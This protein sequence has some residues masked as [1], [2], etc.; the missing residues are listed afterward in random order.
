MKNESSRSRRIPACLA[1][2]AFLYSACGAASAAPT[3]DVRTMTPRYGEIAQS[4]QVYGTIGTAP[5]NSVS[6][7]LPYA[8]RLVQLRVENGQRIARGGA[9]FVVQADP[10]V[11]ATARQAATAAELARGELARTQA[12]FAQSLATRSQLETAR[13][14]ALDAQSALDAQQA[15]GLGNGRVTV[16]APADG[17]VAQIAVLP[18]ER[19]QAGTAILRLALRSA[20][21]PNVTLG[22]D[23]ADAAQLRA[24]DPISVSGLSPALG[25]VRAQGRIVVIGAAVDPQTR[26]VDVD[27]TVALNNDGL[28][29]G[30]H[31]KGEISTRA[32]QHWIIP[33]SALLSDG[34]GEYVYQIGKDL[35]AHR[36]DVVKRIENSD[37]YGVDGDL[38]AQRPLVV[39]GNYELRDGDAVRVE[40]NSPA[41]VQKG[42]AP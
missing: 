12:L 11:M 30:M 40:A 7:N 39:T 15:L 19:V 23:P 31:I 1:A 38:D 5:G 27:A 32:G 17:I 42:T 3:V 36:I 20:G 21:S 8:A 37:D 6:V 41:G 13:K 18:G 35:H 33:R 26:L 34:R 2:L 24:G 25:R 4:V 10:A 16:T 9:L 29:P 22:V 14:A 28:L